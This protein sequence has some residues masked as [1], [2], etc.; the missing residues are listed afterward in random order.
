MS[1][2][3]QYNEEQYQMLC[4]AVTDT[5]S[6]ICLFRAD[7]SSM[8]VAIAERLQLESSKS[9]CV[10]NMAQVDQEELPDSI[11]KMRKLLGGHEDCE[12]VI[13]CNL[14][15]CGIGIGDEKY[16]QYLNHMRDQMLA[17]KK[18]WVFGMSN[19]FAVLLSKQA[20]DLYSCI[21]NHF[22]FRE[23]EEEPLWIFE[24]ND[25]A[26]D[27]KIKLLHFKELQ[28]KIR[29]TGIDKTDISELLAMVAI[30]NDV[31][32]FCTG[33][34]VSWIKKVL[35]RL[36]EN[37]PSSGLTTREAMEYQNLAAAYYCLEK[38]EDSLRIMLAIKEQMGT[39]WSEHSEEMAAVNGE[40]GIIYRK[41]KKYD[42]AEEYLCKAKTYFEDTGQEYSY[43][44]FN[45][46]DIIAQVNVFQGDR[47][48]SISIYKD[49]IEHREK[50]SGIKLEDVSK[51]W[52]NLGAC[53]LAKHEYSYA[54][55]CFLKSEELSQKTGS[56]S[57]RNRGNTLKNIGYVYAKLG[58]NYKAI[59]YME[60]AK[61]MLL[62][63]DE[64]IR[65]T[66]RMKMIDKVMEECRRK[67]N[68]I[69]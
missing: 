67:I 58:D 24:E 59:E 28:A 68:V 6:G 66:D 51:L 1:N 56:A 17:M 54:L 5:S 38:L 55:N 22:E 39:V 53:Y 12:V 50:K 52:N 29:K 62:Q 46:M 47:D 9:C 15:L 19:Y 32:E 41:L 30:W 31:Y 49:L 33:N 8:Q 69:R 64:S 13:V 16:I 37:M 14:Q 65:R 34:T 61:R 57:V 40:L 42:I 48:K 21:M 23:M 60:K 3:K 10:L 36:D 27:I 20:R 11:V 2:W 63:I 25:F 35:T 43:K 7:D 45:I 44:Y 4:L 26:G 18:V